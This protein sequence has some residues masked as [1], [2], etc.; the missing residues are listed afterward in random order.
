MS[1]IIL[2][3][4]TVSLIACNNDNG[5]DNKDLTGTIAITSDTNVFTYTLLTTNYNGREAVSYYLCVFSPP[6]FFAPVKMLRI[7]PYRAQKTVS[8]RR[9][10]MRTKCSY[11]TSNSLYYTNSFILEK[12]YYFVSSKNKIIC[13]TW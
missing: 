13:F 7:F 5:N 6:Y 10:D 9:N 3:G 4:I 1:A 12:M 8:Y 2:I 11:N